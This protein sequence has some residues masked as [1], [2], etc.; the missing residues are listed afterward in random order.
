MIN[1]YG[2]SLDSYKMVIGIQWLESLRPILWDFASRT[3][4]FVHDGH[5]VV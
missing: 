3:M 4:A 2:L 5:R 1:C